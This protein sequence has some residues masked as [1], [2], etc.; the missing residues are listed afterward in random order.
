MSD[1]NQICT[2]EKYVDVGVTIDSSLSF[3]DNII[4]IVCKAYGACY[5]IFCAFQS[6][7]LEFMTAVFTIYVRP[8]LEYGCQI[9]NPHL[10][11]DAQSIVKVYFTTFLRE[12]MNYIHF[13][14][15]SAYQH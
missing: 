8:V 3:R 2:V 9:W 14:I 4:N 6:R 5:Q 15:T 7:N 10:K 12:F 11:N 13:S 1:N